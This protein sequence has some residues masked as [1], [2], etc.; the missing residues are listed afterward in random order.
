[1]IL[2]GCLIAG[3]VLLARA[4]ESERVPL[5]EPFSTL[6]FQFQG[7]QGVRAP[8]LEPDVLAVLS[9]D[10]YVNRVYRAG[11]GMPLGL[12]IGYYESQRQGESM[13]SPLNCLPGSGWQPI[14]SGRQMV[15]I[16][17]AAPIE[18]NRYLV[19]KNGESMLVLYWYQSH[20]RVIASEYWGKYYMVADAIRR[21]Q[22]DAAL[23][24][25]VVPINSKEAAAERKAE[26]A[27]SEFVGALFPLLAR[28][29]PA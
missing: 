27:G 19:Q 3:A 14:S 2:T 7:W 5:R 1:V 23:V 12:Y 28:H 17:G 22:T 8:D 29:L 10:E 15:P 9:V 26:Q 20:G 11:T 13:H 24:R 18:V 16:P 25:V 4:N 6:P 21:N